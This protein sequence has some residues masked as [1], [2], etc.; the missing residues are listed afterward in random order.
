MSEPH[1][2]KVPFTK[3]EEAGVEFQGTLVHAAHHTGITRP[4][5]HN[6]GSH[7]HKAREHAD[8]NI[9]IHGR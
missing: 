6:A 9:K 5:S 3:G 2:S 1:D 7:D 8:H 4:S